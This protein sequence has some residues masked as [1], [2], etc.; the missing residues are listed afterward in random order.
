MILGKLRAEEG[1]E[2]MESCFGYDFQ[3]PI[4]Q[5]A[6]AKI[7]YSKH[8]CPEVFMILGEALAGDRN[9]RVENV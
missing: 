1:C 6:W 2:E 4:S 8:S 3:I 9:S 5:V 7:L